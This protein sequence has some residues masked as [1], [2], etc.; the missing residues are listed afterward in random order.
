MLPYQLPNKRLCPGN[1]HCTTNCA[2]GQCISST[3]SCERNTCPLASWNTT[4]DPTHRGMAW[5]QTCFNLS[6][7]THY[8]KHLLAYYHWWCHQ[9]D[10]VVVL[11]PLQ[12]EKVLWNLAPQL[13]QQTGPHSSRNTGHERYK[14]NQVISFAHM[15]IDKTVTYQCIVCTH[16]S[17]KEEQNQIQLTVGSDHI[18]YEGNVS[19]PIE[20]LTSAKLL[21]SSTIST[22]SAQFT[23][24]LDNSN[25]YL[26]TPL[27]LSNSCACASTTSSLTKSSHGTLTL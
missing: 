23:T 26:N 9:L 2:V 25:F 16:Q 18:N 24:V 4:S 15:P 13:C 5:Q 14:H 8:N 7:K 17:Q 11:T 1:A 3:V 19:T 21:F 10:P 6:N 20:D 27:D 12:D 22:P